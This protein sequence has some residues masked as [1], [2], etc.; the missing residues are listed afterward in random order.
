MS[1]GPDGDVAGNQILNLYRLYPRTAKLVALTDGTGTIHEPAGLD[2]SALAELFRLG[3]GIHKYPPERL[4]EGAFLVDKLKKR[5][6]TAYIQQTLCL[7]KVNG[8][9]QEEWLGGSEVNHL[10][11]H[12]LHSTPA[13]IFVP[14]GGRPRTLNQSNWTDFLDSRGTPTAR[15]IVE[16]ANL[17]LDDTA[18]SRLEAKGTLIIKDSSANKAG[19]ICSSYEALVGLV[20]TE[21]E[22]KSVKETLIAE[23]LEIVKSFARKEAHLLLSTYTATGEPLTAISER[24]SQRINK[25]SYEI[26]D[27]LEKKSLPLDSAHPLIQTYLSH[28]PPTLAKNWQ[29][30]LLDRVPEQHIKAIISCRLA[31]QIVYNKGLSWEPTIVDALPS[32]A[33][34]EIKQ[35]QS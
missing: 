22:F 24:I 17:Y 27:Y 29:K 21:E 12:N 35:S 6:Q 26:L 31:S 13:D 10:L 11:R 34:L 5:S 18:R 3:Q 4:G 32:L 1:G 20:L 9:L 19:V 8:A 16:G 30:A 28:C 33:S 2:L 23:I 7:R 25:F 15:A 14:A